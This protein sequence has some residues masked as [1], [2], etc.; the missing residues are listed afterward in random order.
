MPKKKKEP[1]NLPAPMIT[2]STQIVN[3]QSF[4]DVDRADEESIMAELSGRAVGQVCYSFTV[5]DKSADSGKRTIEGIGWKGAME[6]AR[7][8][9]S[10]GADPQVKPVGDIRDDT[11]YVLVYCIDKANNVGIW[12]NAWQKMTMKRW[13]KF[14][15]K[16][17]YIEDRFAFVKALNKAQRNGILALIPESV[18]NKYIEMWR[19]QGRIKK[20][21]A[22]SDGK[23]VENAQ[24][25]TPENPA[26]VKEKEKKTKLFG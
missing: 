20:I 18:K 22:P 5:K 12:G 3:Y 2:P 21:E 16:D 24:I 6:I 17:E 26:A 4:V 9:K 7:A 8:E 11:M 14:E 10:I 1:E 13:N 19:S 23:K 15:K 25:T